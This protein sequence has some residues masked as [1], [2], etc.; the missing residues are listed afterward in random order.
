M[1]R[2]TMKSEQVEELIGRARVARERAYAPYSRFLV[3][4][5]LLAASGRIYEGCNVE[6]ASPVLGVCAERVAILQAVAAGEREFKALAV[7]S[8]PGA[9][10][11]GACRQVLAEFVPEGQEF[12]VIVA[13]TS[14]RSRAF[15]LGE[16][17]P[18][19]FPAQNLCSMLGT[20]S[21]PEG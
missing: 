2:A 18:H 16:L 7:M 12:L 1:R 6:N 9:M 3:G 20:R 10:P 19:P 5:A 14:G 21:K 8:E 17:L 13:D 11:C 4:A 15:P